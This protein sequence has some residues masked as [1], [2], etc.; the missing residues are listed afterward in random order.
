MCYNFLNS[1]VNVFTAIGPY[2]DTVIA[3]WVALRKPKENVEGYFY[4]KDQ[5]I[6]NKGLMCASILNFKLKNPE[7]HT[8]VW[9]RKSGVVLGLKPSSSLFKDCPSNMKISLA[10]KEDD[11][12]FI[13]PPNNKELE[14][15][16]VPKTPNDVY[17]WHRRG[18]IDKV[19]IYTTNNNEIECQNREGDKKDKVCCAQEMTSNDRI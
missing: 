10:E 13:L 19:Y 4:I 16:F 12:D 6:P 5:R 14:C 17:T 9:R 8:V 3:L 2:A 18:C 7:K 15:R 1:I 11:S